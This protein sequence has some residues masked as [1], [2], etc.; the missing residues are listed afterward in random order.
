[1]A[2]HPDDF[3]VISVTLRHLRDNGNPLD[4]AVL[5]SGASGVEDCFRPDLTTPRK[6][7]L[8]EAEQ[9]ASCRFFGLP[10]GRLAFLRLDEDASG[11][12]EDTA[13][14]LERLRAH[15]LAHPA[16]LVFL[17]HGNDT[18]AAHRRTYA[19]FRRIASSCPDP[20]AALL[21]RDPKTQAMREDVVMPFGAAEAQWKGRMLRF[22][23]TQQQRNLRTRGHGLDERIL[24]VNRQA[25]ARL[26]VR[27]DYAEAFELELYLPE[28][29]ERP[30]VVSASRHVGATAV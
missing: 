30:G 1:L 17:P 29:R 18:N 27:A 21:N 8:R 5:T 22:H 20:V 14:N 26:G 11:H 15:W 4:L 10:E 25:A 23:E 19:M 7:A 9:R 16:D 6:A 13:Q 24:K 28:R 12:L 2:P 3:D